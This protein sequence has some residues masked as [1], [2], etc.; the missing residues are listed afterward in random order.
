MPLHDWT[1]ADDGFFHDFHNTWLIHLKDAL[2]GGVLPAGYFAMTDQRADVYVPDLVAVS[3]GAPP[4]AP[5]AGGT[6]VAEPR[7]ER[8]VVSH[9]YPRARIRRRLMVRTVRRVVGVI[10]I[11]SPGNKDGEQ[12][13]SEFA[14]KVADLVLGG[15]HVAVPD[16]LPPGRHDPA[17]MHARVWAELDE[18]A[19][20]E[21]APPDRP[22]PF[23]GYAAGIPIE[24]FLNY[25][26]VGQP[27]P[28]IPLFLEGDNY[29]N[30]PLEATYTTGFDRLPAELKAVFG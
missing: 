17:G 3:A 5:D 2:N 10:E 6:A 30:L 8:R 12:S 25:A 7:T 24:A 15:I 16:I 14:R 26:A 21:P 18:Q 13:V 22:L 1:K 11:V 27:L 29:V 20:V 19:V 23:A 28:E 9:G 4:A